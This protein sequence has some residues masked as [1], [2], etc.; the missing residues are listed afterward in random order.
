MKENLLSILAPE[1]AK[2]GDDILFR[3][4]RQSSL[5]CDEYAPTDPSDQEIAAWNQ[6]KDVISLRHSGI[7]NKNTKIRSIFNTLGRLQT[8]EDRQ[9]YMEKANAR[10]SLGQPKS[11]EDNPLD[12]RS[13]TTT[14]RS[15]PLLA[16]TEKISSLLK[17]DAN[18][19]PCPGQEATYVDLLLKYLDNKQYGQPTC[20]LCLEIFDSWSDVW[21]HSNVRHD[22]ETMWP[23]DCPECE[24][25]GDE[26]SLQQIK[27][28]GEWCAHVHETHAPGDQEPFR[29]LL[30]CRTFARRRDVTTHLKKCHRQLWDTSQ[31]LSCP[32]CERRGVE[33]PKFID[34]TEFW[35]HI[36]SVHPSKHLPSSN[37]SMHRCLL[38]NAG[39]FAKQSAL[40][41]HTTVVHVKEESIFEK[42]FSCPECHR[43]NLGDHIIRDAADWC[44]H[45]AEHHSSGNAAHP[46]ALIQTRCLL[47]DELLFNER[48]HFMSIHWKKGQFNQAFP[49]PECVRS[50]GEDVLI[51][52]YEDWNLHCATVHGR[53]APAMARLKRVRA[54]CL[55]CNE[56]YLSLSSHVSR[57][58]EAE[59]QFDRPFQCPECTRIGD[60]D[61]VPWVND[62]QAWVAHCAY[63][64]KDTSCG[65]GIQW[66]STEKQKTVE[67]NGEKSYQSRTSMKRS[68]EEG[69]DDQ[70]Q[71]IKRREFRK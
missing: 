2:E 16:V 3:M 32:E 46:S 58:H 39:S 35:Q 6:R 12:D 9:Q 62:R 50:G 40:S 49:C 54:R 13:S 8:K 44:T 1:T 65:T 31:P 71:R 25:Q 60:N 22:G 28:L 41:R 10:R 20:F 27:N 38:C 59:G 26:A 24:R 33:S 69:E 56:H 61:P 34:P 63:I 18:V 14:T 37:T 52:C 21:K 45:V 29:C 57:I 43:L 36:E 5:K 42:A 19:P 67:Y 47:C 64:H 23:L 17:G 11:L 66:Q 53:P 55:L 30:G 51:K 15:Y 7:Y 4:L 70:T 68:R 48:S